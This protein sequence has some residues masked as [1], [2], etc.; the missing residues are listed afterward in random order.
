MH[1]KI[2]LLALIIFIANIVLPCFAAEEPESFHAKKIIVEDLSIEDALTFAIN[3]PSLISKRKET[4]AAEQRIETTKWLRFPSVSVQTSAGQSSVSRTGGTVITTLRLDQPIWA[5]GRITNSIDSAAA[6]AQSA[7][8]AQIEAEQEFLI[9][10]TTSF[11]NFLKYQEKLDA[12][13]ESMN[14]HQRL[15]EMIQ[16]KARQDVSPISE[17]ILAKSRFEQAKAE[18]IQFQTF[19]ANTKSDLENYTNRSVL[20]L[21]SPRMA[22]VLPPNINEAVKLALDFSPQL[23]KIAADKDAAEA[24]IGVAKSVLWPQISARSDQNF[25]GVLEGNLT[26]LALTYT[27]G[28]GLASISGIREAEVKRDA[29]EQI[30]IAFK[31][32]LTNKINLLWNQYKSETSQV[33]VLSNLAQTSRGVYLSFVRQYAAGKK[34]WPEVLNAR[35]EATQAKYQLAESQWNA[36]VAGI[37]L[38]IHT[39]LISSNFN[40][41]I[42]KAE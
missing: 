3:H 36:F 10:T 40:S 5:G 32:D 16:R 39:G 33:E 2:K 15:L 27:P 28:N 37:S 13:Q 1:K 41:V 19:F 20:N 8:F 21:K 26:Y 14:E 29:S 7:T 18:N 31:L 4:L 30:M 42:N 12:S 35:K 22:L 38:G 9:K 25:G 17:V 6:K 11:A 24:D 34:T 23:K